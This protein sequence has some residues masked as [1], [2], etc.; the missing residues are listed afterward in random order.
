M[1][2]TTAICIKTA[3]RDGFWSRIVD[4]DYRNAYCLDVDGDWRNRF[5]RGKLEF[6]TSVG[7]LESDHPLNDGRWYH[8]AV[9]EL[10]DQ[11]LITKEQCREKVKEIMD[12]L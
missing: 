10:Y 8:I 11:G 12:S 1:A 4:E 2:Y 5:S 7:Y 9:K 3:K 6:E